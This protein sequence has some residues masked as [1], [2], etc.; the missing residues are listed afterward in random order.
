[1]KFTL[2]ATTGMFAT[3]VSTG[4][5]NSFSGTASLPLAGTGAGVATITGGADSI[6]IPADAAEKHHDRASVTTDGESRRGLGEK[7]DGKDPDGQTCSYCCGKGG[8]R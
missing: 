8:C 2:V 5:A 3:L 6:S 1:M 7:A 4:L